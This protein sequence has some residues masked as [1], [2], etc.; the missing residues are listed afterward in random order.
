MKMLREVKG[1]LM[2]LAIAAVLLIALYFLQIFT[3][4][5]RVEKEAPL[6]PEGEPKEHLL[7]QKRPDPKQNLLE[8]IGDGK[9]KQMQ[10]HLKKI[11]ESSR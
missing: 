11:R 4:P 9:S 8:A 10:D 3:T 1:I 6:D 5:E 2:A 7:K